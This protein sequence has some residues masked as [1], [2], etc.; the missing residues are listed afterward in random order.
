MCNLKP[1]LAA[2]S[3]A[4]HCLHAL[5]VVYTPNSIT[6]NDAQQALLSLE[7]QGAPIQA[8]PTCPKHGNMTCDM[9]RNST[10]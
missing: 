8:G 6:A 3:R 10:G 5:K 9:Q 7:F 2:C 1:L 4:F